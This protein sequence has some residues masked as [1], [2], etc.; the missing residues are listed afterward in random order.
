MQGI[1]RYIESRIAFYDTELGKVHEYSSDWQTCHEC[2]RELNNV[3]AQIRKA[4][5]F[6]VIGFS[7]LRERFE[8]IAEEEFRLARNSAN[9]ISGA[10]YLEKANAFMLAIQIASELL[11]GVK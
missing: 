3:I 8:S 7:E 2:K 5:T 9:A 4:K 6:D 11:Q 1:I 10:L